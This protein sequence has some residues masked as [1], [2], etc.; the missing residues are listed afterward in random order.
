MRGAGQLARP[1]CSFKHFEFQSNRR[2]WYEWRRSDGRNPSER[3]RRVPSR[4]SVSTV[5]RGMRQVGY[6]ACPVQAG[7]H[8]Q[9]DCR[10]HQPNYER[11][12]SRRVLHAARTR[13][14]KFIPRGGA[15]VLGQRPD[16]DASGRAGCGASGSK[17]GF[18]R[19]S[20][21]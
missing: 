14:G 17:P 19:G 13:H 18:L 21:L 6:S 5:D 3:R 11:Q 15:G 10:W 12:A 8:G 7:A 16:A 20:S 2:H 4:F 9:R 1:F